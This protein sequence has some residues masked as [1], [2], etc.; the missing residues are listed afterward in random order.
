M[1]CSIYWF[2]ADLRLLDN[3]QF[4]NACQNSK[5]LLPVFV[6][7]LQEQ[8]PWGFERVSKQRFAWLHQSVCDLRKSLEEKGST[9]FVVEGDPKNALPAL[10]AQVGADVIYCEAIAAP[11]EQSDI[12]KLQK[13]G[14]TINTQ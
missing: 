5:S 3:P 9:L 7:P 11:E 1:G 10:C 4:V 2:R 13:A 12:L 14:L 6:L 8:T